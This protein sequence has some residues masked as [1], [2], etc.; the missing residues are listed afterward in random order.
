MTRTTI[1]TDKTDDVKMLI[2]SDYIMPT[3]S[4]CDA[5][6]TFTAPKRLTAATGLDALTHAIEAYISQKA[7]PYTDII[8]LEAIR[9]ISKYLRQAWSNGRDVEARYYMMFAATMAGL[10]FSNSSVCLVHGMSRP[11]GAIFHVPHGLSNAVLLP[12]VMRFTLPGNIRKFAKIA[13]AMGE[14]VSGL[15]NLEAAEK[16]VMAVERL[17]KDFNMLGLRNAG[18]KE[19]DLKRFAPKMAK[20]AIASGSPANNPRIATEEEIIQLYLEAF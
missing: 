14:S 13:E 8:A 4:I 6:L 19:E 15:S 20:D 5:Q 18:V 1:I 10:A 7:Q 3:V 11:I 12:A 9:L 17:C 2:I 16:S